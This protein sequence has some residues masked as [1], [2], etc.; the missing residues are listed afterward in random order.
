LTRYSARSG[1]EVW[2]LAVARPFAVFRE[3]LT[4][5]PSAL[6]ILMKASGNTS[7][8]CCLPAD[9]HQ[10]TQHKRRDKLTFQAAKHHASAAAL[11]SEKNHEPSTI[12]TQAFRYFRPDSP[13]RAV[14]LADR[15]YP[16]GCHQA[17][18]STWTN[19]FRCPSN[20]CECLTTGP[21]ASEVFASL[22]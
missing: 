13:L 21:R 16:K 14:S 5:G 4:T 17:R 1:A 20:C 7:N 19:E 8:V 15:I 18:S 9:C 2:S 3:R 11:P 6:G 22:A 12:R 10:R